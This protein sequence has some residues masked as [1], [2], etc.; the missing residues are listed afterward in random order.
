M[1][2]KYTLIVS[3]FAVFSMPLPVRAQTMD[4]AMKIQNIIDEITQVR[5]LLK[6]V[7]SS[8]NIESMMKNLAGGGDWKGALKGVAGGIFDK[9]GDRAGT[10]ESLIIVPDGLDSKLDDPAASKEWMRANLKEKKDVTVAEQAEQKK[11]VNTFLYTSIATAYG[12]SVA[13]RKK[14]DKEINTIDKLRQDAEGKESETDL[15]NEINRINLLKLEQSSYTQQLL[16]TSEQ[17]NSLNQV[18][19]KS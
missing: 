15:Q 13:V 3:A 11:N 19:G 4:I 9:G 8:A 7:Q 10:K 18:L 12:K 17:N 5:A 1:L 16:A 2:R 14:M 6:Q